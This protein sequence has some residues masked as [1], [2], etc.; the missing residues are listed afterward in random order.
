LCNQAVTPSGKKMSSNWKEV[1]CKNC[2]KQIKANKMKYDIREEM[3]KRAEKKI[4]QEALWE[5]RHGVFLETFT[6]YRLKDAFED[7]YGKNEKTK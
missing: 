7:I 6:R 1:T 3:W 4:W 5:A 2:L